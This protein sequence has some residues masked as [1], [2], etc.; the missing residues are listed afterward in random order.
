MAANSLIAFFIQVPQMQKPCTR[1]KIE[2]LREGTPNPVRKDIKPMG[3]LSTLDFGLY[4]A[5]VKATGHQ[6]RKI[7]RP[8]FCNGHPYIKN[9]HTT[10]S[11]IDRCT[12]LPFRAL[13]ILW[14]YFLCAEKLFLFTRHW[15]SF[16]FFW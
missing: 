11:S 3:I 4:T 6:N 13:G 2:K 10:E 8:F 5:F 9:K 16:S 7:Y 1:R 15:F 12:C 14:Q